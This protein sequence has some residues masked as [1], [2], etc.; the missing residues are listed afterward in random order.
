MVVD[1]VPMQQEMP[2]VTGSQISS[3]DFTNLFAT[4]VGSINPNDIESITVLKD[5][6][7]AAIYGSPGGRRRD[8]GDDQTRQGRQDPCE[9]YKGSVS[10]QTSPSRSADLMNSREKLAWEQELWDEFSA[11]GFAASQGGPSVHYP[12]VGIVGMIRSGYGKYAGMSVAEQDARI[13]ELGQHTT[14]WFDALFRNSVATSHHLSISGGTEKWRS[15][16]RSVTGT[17]TVSC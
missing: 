3:G 16:L 10:V 8:R 17:T 6:A 5:A 4:G 14:D 2:E 7:A 15:I 13:A 9:L 1:G 12:V 11:A